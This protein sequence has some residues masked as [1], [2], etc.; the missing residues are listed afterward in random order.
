MQTQRLRSPGIDRERDD[1][2]YEKLDQKDESTG[3]AQR[4][5]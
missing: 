4:C 5:K 3:K 2:E 1:V